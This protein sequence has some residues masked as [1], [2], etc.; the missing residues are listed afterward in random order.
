MWVTYHCDLLKGEHN[1]KL[2]LRHSPFHRCKHQQ[3]K[4]RDRP[5]EKAW[6]AVVSIFPPPGGATGTVVHHIFFA[7]NPNSR[8]RPS[9][10]CAWQWISRTRS[11]QTSPCRFRSQQ[12]QT[13]W[14]CPNVTGPLRCVLPALC[15]A[16]HRVFRRDRYQH[17]YC[18]LHCTPS[19]H[20]GC[21]PEFLGMSLP[22]RYWIYNLCLSNFAVSLHRTWIPR[23][24][25]DLIG[26]NIHNAIFANRL[27]RRHI[28]VRARWGGLVNVLSMTSDERWRNIGVLYT[29]HLRNVNTL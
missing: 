12:R 27:H 10:G 14:C 25:T 21:W 9:A 28:V 23:L 26:H 8:Q 3:T 7:S 6:K 17:A 5:D 1:H 13:N 19:L 18:M 4:K 22:I 2:L 15:D 16:S 24:L 20:F 29:T 11:L